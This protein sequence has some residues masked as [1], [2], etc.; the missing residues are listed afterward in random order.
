MSG[1]V[2]EAGRWSVLDQELARRVKLVGFDVDGVLTDGTVFMGL[3]AHHPLEFKRFYV[4]DGLGIKLL[5]AAGLPVVFVSARASEA[6]ETRAQELE[7]DELLEV[8]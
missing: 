3:V 7:V 8:A 5:K 1:I 2:P 4:P 6:T